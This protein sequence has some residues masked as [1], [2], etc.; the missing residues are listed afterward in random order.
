MQLKNLNTKLLGKEIYYYETIDSTQKEIWK[1]IK[2][3]NIKNGTMIMAE[4]QTEAYGTHGRTWYTEV[5]N[6]I[7]L[8]FYI[9]TKCKVED[10][11]RMSI[12]IAKIM[13]EV[14]K[15]L[16]NI[17]LEIKNPNDIV[18][19]GKKIGGILTETKVQNEEVKC[20]VVGIGM[21]TNQEKFNNDIENIASSVKKEFGISIDNNLVIS[22]FC[23]FFEKKFIYIYL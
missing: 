22:K 5:K 16:Y 20:I 4:I 18:F 10:I 1:R 11:K 12:D 15:E 13:I 2:N 23:E 21:N 6:N 7:A 17:T 14:F 8:S 3:K 9:E 19:K